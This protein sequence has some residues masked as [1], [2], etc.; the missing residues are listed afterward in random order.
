MLR[1]LQQR[2]KR[3]GELDAIKNAIDANE[4]K[5][6]R[7]QNYFKERLEAYQQFKL[8]KKIDGIKY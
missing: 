2:D 1:T 8:E 6:E 3:E 4:L 7:L 5:K